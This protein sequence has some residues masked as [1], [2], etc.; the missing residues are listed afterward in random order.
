MA[1]EQKKNQTERSGN[2][3]TSTIFTERVG[4]V[5]IRMMLD[6]RNR[7]L[8]DP[9]DDSFPLCLRFVLGGQRYHYKLGEQFTEEELKAIRLSTGFGEKME[10]GKETRF[11]TKMRLNSTFMQYVQT[12]RT[13]N[14]TGSL[15]LD[16][17]KTALTG[18]SSESSLVEFWNSIVERK[19]AAGQIGTANSYLN[20]LKSFVEHTKFT[21]KDGFN[22]DS[23]VVNKWIDGMTKKLVR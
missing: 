18:R 11:Q 2:R 13:L 19:R 5:S 4:D 3:D 16:R 15:T 8:K 10:E 1:M 9:K 6:I 7:K 22:V 14:D 20:A 17:I 21:P 23:T 12:V